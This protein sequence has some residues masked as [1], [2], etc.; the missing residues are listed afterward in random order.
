MTWRLKT[1]DMTWHGLNANKDRGVDLNKERAGWLFNTCY[2]SIL[3]FSYPTV[4]L[5]MYELYI[6]T[7]IH[8]LHMYIHFIYFKFS[9][10]YIHLLSFRSWLWV[11]NNRVRDSF[12]L[13][14]YEDLDACKAHLSRVCDGQHECWSLEQLYCTYCL[15]FCLDGLL[16]L[17]TKT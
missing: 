16:R 8:T 13:R 9:W 2:P 15:F 12:I 11:H 7:Y 5:H 3:C 4:F 1:C 17:L 6:H 14:L 10:F